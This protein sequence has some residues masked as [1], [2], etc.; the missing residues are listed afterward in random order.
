MSRTV[1]IA[2]AWKEIHLTPPTPL[3]RPT[4]LPFSE[5]HLSDML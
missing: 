3:S 4:S 2:I 1:E 5:M